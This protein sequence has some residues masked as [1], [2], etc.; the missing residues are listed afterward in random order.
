MQTGPR[1]EGVREAVPWLGQGHGGVCHVRVA[2]AAVVGVEESG[3]GVGRR[4]VV[5]QEEKTVA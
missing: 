2:G 3:L 5:L 1:H 4:K